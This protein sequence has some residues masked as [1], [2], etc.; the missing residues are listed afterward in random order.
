MKKIVVL[1]FLCFNLTNAQELLPI[2][3]KIYSAV[4]RLKP[5]GMIYIN[6]EG[7][8]T[9]YRTND[10]GEFVIYPKEKK[11]VYKLTIMAGSHQLLHYDFK[12]EWLTRKHPKSIVVAS[13]FPA[14]K[15]IA[16]E[17]F[18]KGRLQLYVQ[19]GIA[20]VLNSKKDENFEKKYDVTYYELGCQIKTEEAILQYNKMAFL[21]LDLKYGKAWRR[22]VRKDV[23]GLK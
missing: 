11:E 10:D 12:S 2:R 21:L 5:I 6:L 22:K 16:Q 18:K 14:S 7:D 17:D 23:V 19:G 8:D 20:P 4:T 3:G 9:N 1:V 13:N 15:I